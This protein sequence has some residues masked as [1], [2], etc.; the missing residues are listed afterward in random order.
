LVDRHIPLLS[1][2]FLKSVWNSEFENYKKSNADAILLSRLNSWSERQF[3]KETS[4]ESGFEQRFFQEIWGYVQSGANDK[5]ISSF[6]HYPKFPIKGGSAKGGTGE[7]DSALGRFSAETEHIPQVVCEYKDIKSGLNLPQSRGTDK[8]TPVR[9][10]LDYLAAAQRNLPPFAPISPAW[11]IVTDM[12]EFR[13]YWSQRGDREYIKFVIDPRQSQDGLFAGKGLLENTEEARFD[14]FLFSKIFSAD[15][16]LV[17]GASGSSPLAKLIER[18]WIREKALEKAFYEEYRAFRNSLYLALLEHNGEGTNRFPGTRGRLVRLAQKILDRFIFVFF[19][20]DMGGRISYPPQLLRDFLIQKAGDEYYDPGEFNI[21]NRLKSLFEKMNTGGKFGPHPVNK[22]NGGLFSSD[23]ELDA[24]LI[25]NRI[26]CAP[27]QGLNEASLSQYKNTLLYMSARY[28]YATGFG[29]S[30][31]TANSEA[32]E[33]GLYTLG[34]IFEQSITEL[35]VLEAEAD[36]KVSLNKITKRKRDGVYYTP[37]WVVE[38]LVNDTLGKRLQEIKKECGWPLSISD[39]AE[40]RR[41]RLKSLKAYEARLKDIKIVDPAC[42]SGA[43]LITALRHLTQEWSELRFLQSADTKSDFIPPGDKTI[44]NILTQNLYGVDINASSVEIAKLALWLHTANG[45]TALSSLDQT[46]R[47]GNS[48]IGPEFFDSLAEP[49][50]EERERINPFDWQSAFPE[51]FDDDRPNGPG[52][53]VVVGNPPYVKLQHFRKAHADMAQFLQ[54]DRAGNI[55]YKSTQTKNFDLYLPFIEKGISLLNETGRLGY[56]APNVWVMNQYGEGLRNLVTDGKHLTGWIDF[57]SHQIF[58]E[59]TVYTALQYFTKSANDSVTVIRAYDGQIEP[60][61][62]NDKSRTLSYKKLVFRDRWLL[63]TG[64]DRSIIDTAM[65]RSKF[66]DDTSVTSRIYQGLITSADDIYHLEKLGTGRY[67]CHPNSSRDAAS[68]DVEIEDEIMKPLVSG[69]EAKR[70][71]TPETQTYLLFPYTVTKGKAGLIPKSDM[72]SDFP[73]A[74]AYLKSWETELRSRESGKFDGKEWH[75]FG[76][77]QN[78][79][80]QENEKLIVPRLVTRVFTSVDKTG[81]F[82]LDN[83]DVG[84]VVAAKETTSEYLSG[85]LNSTACGYIFRLISKPFRGNFRSA[86]KQF[87]APLPIPKAKKKVAEDIAKRA[88]ELQ[89][90]HTNRRDI[91]SDIG[92]RLKSVPPLKKPDHWLFPELPVP[93][94][95]ALSETETLAMAKLAYVQALSDRHDDLTDAMSPGAELSSRLLKGEIQF[96][97][98]NIPV[99]SGIFPE[100]SKAEFLLAQWNYVASTFRITGRTKGKTLAN[101]LRTLARTEETGRIDQVITLQKELLQTEAAISSLEV[102]M[103][104]LIYTLYGLSEDQI[105]H[106]ETLSP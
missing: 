1:R 22:F 50:A 38:R 100:Q 52:F 96:L 64:K 56:I 77:S 68:Y 62:W 60:D 82:Y 93:D 83:V 21:W 37:E 5:K 73:K 7:A 84:G 99:I 9:Q 2:S 12:N 95:S 48:L 35:E 87:I 97:I 14:R 15:L 24:L 61:P 91:I 57:G 103:D 20:E 51:V 86:N 32:T 4:A 40:D 106:I 98:D 66:L 19:C 79:G 23:P 28:N 25:P 13:L 54:M 71:I 72:K 59:A 74:W 6:T 26:F 76:R 16:L 104:T 55:S 34:R 41:K 58:D 85:I 45:T 75:Q 46:I 69:S 101:A 3:Q 102:E 42:G 8:R 88:A 70:Y 65:K 80:R 78:L 47:E 81:K 30:Q 31:D 11:A 10:A 92:R 44:R 49:T 43:F 36:G 17:K 33:L 94:K 89:R 53:D 63:V 105:D 27:G 67:R 29:A 18:Q 90:F 39:R